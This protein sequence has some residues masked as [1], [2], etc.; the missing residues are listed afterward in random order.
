MTIFLNLL[1][2]LFLFFF[3]LL[4]FRPCPPPSSFW[5]PPKRSFFTNLCVLV[6]LSGPS[7]SFQKST[8]DPLTQQSV[9]L[10][11]T[12]LETCVYELSQDLPLMHANEELKTPEWSGGDYDAVN[13]MLPKQNDDSTQIAGLNTRVFFILFFLFFFTNLLLFFT[14]HAR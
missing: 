2:A 6:N 9:H 13:T 5:F 10:G 12:R 14:G 7:D 8:A 11:T 3:F 1:L 4:N